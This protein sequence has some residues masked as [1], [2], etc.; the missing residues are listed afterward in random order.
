M[1]GN[2][3][4]TDS[5][6]RRSSLIIVA[7]YG[8]PKNRSAGSC[9]DLISSRQPAGTPSDVHSSISTPQTCGWSPRTNPPRRRR[10]HRHSSGWFQWGGSSDGSCVLCCHGDPLAIQRRIR[11]HFLKKTE[12]RNN[13]RPT[14]HWGSVPCPRT[15]GGIRPFTPA[16]PNKRHGY[17]RVSSVKFA[18]LHKHSFALID[19]LG[20]LGGGLV[21]IGEGR[22]PFGGGRVREGGGIEC[23]MQM[24]PRPW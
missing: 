3:G 7:L 13:K 8:I 11:G 20:V 15:R 17:T 1:N 21:M 4:V 16:P 23:L 12:L 9:S 14:V 19:S 6:I 22:G 10:Q 5:S 18:A 24:F 2:T